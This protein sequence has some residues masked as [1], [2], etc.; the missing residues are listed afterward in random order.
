MKINFKNIIVTTLFLISV[1]SAFAE[2]IVW[3]GVDKDTGDV[4]K[5]WCFSSL[6]NCE[7]GK[8]WQYICVAMPKP[9]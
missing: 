7:Q 2:Q 4:N 5:Y 6:Q 1:D 8:P 3:C 9:K